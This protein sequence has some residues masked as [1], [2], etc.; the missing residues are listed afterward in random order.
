MVSNALMNGADEVRR[1]IVVESEGELSVG[2]AFRVADLVHAGSQF[3][4][5]D[6]ISGRRLV[7][8]AVR[9]RSG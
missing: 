3:D 2:V 7:R 1:F 4:Q 6:F 8:S 9:H 5:D